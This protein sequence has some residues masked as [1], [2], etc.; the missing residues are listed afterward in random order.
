L[1]ASLAIS[2]DAMG[3]DN[4]PE[5]VVR[6]AD[7]ARRRFP[8]SKFLFFGD[9]AKVRPL[10]DSLPELKQVSTIRH[11]VSVVTMEDKPGQALRAGRGSSMRLAIDAVQSGEASAVVSAGNTGA[12]MAMAKFVLKT[13]PGID[14]PAIASFFPTMRSESVMLDLGANVQ[15][16]ADNLVQFAVMGNVF[17]RTVLGVREPTMGLLNVGSEEMKGHDAVK[18]AAGIL[19]QASLPGKFVGF[20][21][22][23]DITR[24][25]VDVIVTDGFTG[26][27]ALKSIEG[28]VKLYSHFLRQTFKSSWIAGLGY[29]LARPA[30]NALRARVDPRR[31]NGAIF[32]GLNGVCV[33]SHGGTDAFGFANAIGVAVDMIQNG[34]IEKMREDFGNLSATMSSAA[35]PQAAAL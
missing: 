25:T 29:L 32:M 33:K 18:V 19:R 9:E 26:N 22:G 27:V 30:M 12:L 34:A 35:E 10:L 21:E 13:M 17:A 24:G 11:T 20:V 14:R 2:L 4:A 15:C 8:Q 3:G 16:D 5:M 31:Y 28:A 7:I 6:G 1:S 23:D